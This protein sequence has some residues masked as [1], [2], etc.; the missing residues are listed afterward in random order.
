MTEK[1]IIREREEA[2]DE[3]EN[4]YNELRD[5]YIKSREECDKLHTELAYLEKDYEE[6]KKKQNKEKL[7]TEEEI[8]DLIENALM[9]CGANPNKIE[10]LEA[11]VKSLSDLYAETESERD[12]LRRKIRLFALEKSCQDMEFLRTA[13]RVIYGPFMYFCK[14]HK[15]RYSQKDV[16]ELIEDV[17]GQY[18]QAIVRDLEMEVKGNE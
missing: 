8:F 6:L 5:K 4:K 16:V 14:L 17:L 7:Y 13:K 3:L 1:E 12:E 18:R 2:Y 9:R 11:R 15:R 10:D